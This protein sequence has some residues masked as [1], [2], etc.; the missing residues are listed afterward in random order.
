V[1]EP[2]SSGQESGM[3][4]PGIGHR[5]VALLEAVKALPTQEIDYEIRKLQAVYEWALDRCGVDFTV[6]DRVRIKEGYV[7]KERFSDGHPNGWWPLRE[8]LVPGATAQVRAIDFNGAHHYWYADIV[9]DR[10]WSVHAP[11][12]RDGKEVRYWAGRAED[13]PEGMTP[14]STYDQEHHPDGRRHLFSFDVEWLEKASPF[15]ES[16]PPRGEA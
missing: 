15:D 10:E 8:C 16:R 5:T 4:V 3:T 6:G 7:V 11:R 14:P 12:S 9:L 13:T 2:S 1:D